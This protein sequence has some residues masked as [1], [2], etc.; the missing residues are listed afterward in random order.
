MRGRGLVVVV[1]VAALL[2]ALNACKPLQVDDP[3]YFWFA[4]Q[5][6]AHPSD[7]YGF[8]VGGHV[9]A[10]HVLAPP[11]FPYWCGLGL[12]LLGDGPPAAKLWLFPVCLLLT[13]ALHALAARF[14]PG[15]EAAV[16]VLA[17]FSPALLPG[18][19]LM[20]DVPALALGLAATV[21]FLRA[22]DRRSTPLALA[23]GLVLALALQTKYSA[24][25]V[26]PV[27]L[28]HAVRTRQPWRGLALAGLALGLFAAWEAWVAAR[29][30]E[31]HFLHSL[32]HQPGSAI[33]PFRLALPF[34]TIL[35][36]VAVVPGLLL[37]RAGGWP[38]RHLAL[39]VVV[40]AAGYVLLA[41][42]PDE[43]AV[44]W[45]RKG[46]SV[47]TLNHLV[48]GPPGLLLA[49]LLG[50][51]VARGLRA[52]RDADRFLA[53]WLLAE[54]LTACALSPFPAV[55][56]VLGLTTVAVL[57]AVRALGRVFPPEARAREE[58]FLRWRFRLQGSRPEAPAKGRALKP[59]T[60]AKEQLP[61]A[62]TSGWCAQPARGLLAWL[63]AVQVVLGL[64][65]LVVD[66]RAAQA[67][68]RAV[69]EAG[70][71]LRERAPGERVW[72][73]SHCIR[74]FD[75]YAQELDMYRV[76]AGPRP[77]RAGDWLLA[78]H[79]PGSPPPE[80]ASH[81]TVSPVG[82][83]VLDDGLPFRTYPSYYCGRTAL[84]HHQGPR[85]TVRVYR[86]GTYR[87]L[88]SR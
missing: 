86:L 4:R 47:L 29:Y 26:L 7:P 31:S 76:D 85:L 65:Y 43:A 16:V 28:L 21:V 50:Q 51:C 3:V 2:A 48:F 69:E 27:L 84:E 42:V 23:A 79:R 24:G 80:D 61:F 53:A 1:A 60:Q 82:T 81:W 17:A 36:A 83:V 25:A 40:L 34:V 74:G 73:D 78:V 49:G 67:E 57:A 18:I 5:I 20:L 14:C 44:L 41:V 30:G 35:G 64:F 54:A 55:R 88:A 71:L 70:A 19:G 33:R 62:R 59:E 11:V 15:R 87:Q 56:R 13:A 12:R 75:F 46:K 9:P 37:L 38:G 52:G 68:Q 39:L 32:A 8:R 72:Y 6:A 77:P 22:C 45:A 10:N 63:A 66:L 58:V